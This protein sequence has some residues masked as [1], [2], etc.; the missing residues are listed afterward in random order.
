MT[1]DEPLSPGAIG[2]AGLDAIHGQQLRSLRAEVAAL[3]A[4][5]GLLVEANLQ[6]QRL[7]PQAEPARTLLRQGFGAPTADDRATGIV[8][9]KV[10]CPTCGATINDEL[11]V[12]EERCVFC[13][14]TI[15]TDR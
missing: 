1:H 5:V 8:I 3:R 2:S 12:T 11:G 14:T 9:G 7:D 13:G 10:P 6:G 4:V 15:H